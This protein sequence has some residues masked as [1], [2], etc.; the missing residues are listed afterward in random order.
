[1]SCLA[2]LISRHVQE[3][4]RHIRLEHSDK[5]AVAIIASTW[6]TAFNF[7]IP[8]S[9][10][11]KPDPWIATLGSMHR[12]ICFCLSKTWKPLICSLKKTHE[13]DARPI[14]LRSCSPEAR[15][16]FLYHIQ[17]IQNFTSLDYRA[18]RVV[19]YKWLLS[20]YIF[21]T[22]FVATSLFT[23]EAGLTR[24]GIV[25]STTIFH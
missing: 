24:E 14:R 16:T 25:S 19:C 7:T 21:S 2:L 12:E 8:P 11:Q 10:P 9:S 13:Y 23:D 18:A 5:S 3:H 22:Q 15:P 6:D 1:L 17:R 20:Q 4:Q